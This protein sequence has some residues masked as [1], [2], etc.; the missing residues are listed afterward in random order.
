MKYEVAVNAET[1]LAIATETKW[2]K[3]GIFKDGKGYRVHCES[4]TPFNAMVF[5][6][7]RIK[8]LIEQKAAA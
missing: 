3:P 1:G 2:A 5:A 8:R 6:V 4:D 7:L